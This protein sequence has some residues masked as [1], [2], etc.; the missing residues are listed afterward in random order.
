MPQSATSNWGQLYITPVFKAAKIVSEGKMLSHL[1][2]DSFAVDLLEKGVPM[3]E[4]S[5]FLGCP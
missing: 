1:L 4:V 3:E 5:R 2:R